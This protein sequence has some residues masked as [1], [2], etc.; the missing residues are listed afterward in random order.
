[1]LSVPLVAH[2]TGIDVTGEV[3]R[4]KS[5]RI[6]AITAQNVMLVLWGNKL[7][8]VHQPIPGLTL[9]LVEEYYPSPEQTILNVANI[10]KPETKPVGR[11][12]KAERPA[13]PEVA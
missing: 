5:L 4:L 2:Y 7:I 9:D 6:V 10:S 8:P 13:D 11:P 3:R 12:R 1:M